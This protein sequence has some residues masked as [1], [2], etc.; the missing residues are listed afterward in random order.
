MS[1][2]GPSTHVYYPSWNSL[3]Y[4]A[5]TS[6]VYTVVAAA[7]I[8]LLVFILGG[9]IFL[10]VTR[11]RNKKYTHSTDTVRYSPMH[12][13]DHS[14][15]EKA[16]KK[17]KKSKKRRDP[18]KRAPTGLGYEAAPVYSATTSKLS[19]VPVSPHMD[20]SAGCL[21][22]EYIEDQKQL[23][24][25]WENLC[26]YTPE[27]ASTLVAEMIENRP[28]NRPDSYPYDHSRVKLREDYTEDGRDY[29][30]ASFIVDTDPQH[31]KYIA[32]QAPLEKT[33]A[34]F[35]QMVW[36]KEV[37]VIVM[38]STPEDTEMGQSCQYWP[39]GG[40]A[41]YHTFEVRLVSEHLH[42][43]DYIIRSF[44]M[45]NTRTYESRTVTHSQFLCWGPT[46]VPDEPGP[47]LE[48]RR[49]VNKAHAGQS[50]P[51]LVH[52]SD[53][54]GRTGT[55]I[56]IDMALTRVQN[57]A[58]ELNLAATVEHLRDHRPRMVPTKAQFEFALSAL[59]EETRA[60]LKAASERQKTS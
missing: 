47:L 37:S 53:G 6:T 32:T 46:A 23:E 33:I 29:I 44:I 26:S 2:P 1:S 15:D 17:K 34:D 12:Q 58:K 4:T 21:I 19:S 36:E 49:K 28:K 40:I 13:N 22:L 8:V 30:N 7:V 59:M 24:A 55:Y 60:M 39:T 43:E 31:P 45:Q 52:C 54:V 14:D 9:L 35:W 51:L 56:L 18:S 42:C 20:V 16:S 5:L 27:A 57:G 11:I 10:Y 38:L 3:M 48:F 41:T 25:E 50:T